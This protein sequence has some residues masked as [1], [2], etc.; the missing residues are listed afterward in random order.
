M[1]DLFDS[2]LLAVARRS[3]KEDNRLWE[4]FQN[5]RRTRNTFVHEGKAIIG[6]APVDVVE[7]ARL[8]GIAREIL[9]WVDQLLPGAHRRPVYDNPDQFENTIRLGGHNSENEPG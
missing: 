7:A 1:T 6:G 8:I 4:G 9:D 5:L 3:L 2:L